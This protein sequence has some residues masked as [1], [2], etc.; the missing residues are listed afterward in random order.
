MVPLANPE[1]ETALIELGSTLAKDRD[2][3]LVAVHVVTIPDQTPLPEAAARIEDF[4]PGSG[5]LLERARQD[6]DTFDVPIETHRILS[7]RSFEE[8]SD[9][10]R[11]HRADMVVM[12]WGRHGAPGRMEST[13]DGLTHDL[14]C[15]FLVLRDRSM[16]PDRV[17]VPTA[18]GPDSELSARVASV[19]QRG[20]DAEIT[21]LHVADN[22]NAGEKFLRE[23][24]TENGSKGANLRVESGDVEN[25]IETAAEDATMVMVTPI[26]RRPG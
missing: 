22:T 6:A 10:A 17:L 21:L 15:D 1:H 8:I 9:A 14:P 18:G 3:E 13:I 16:S 25:A 19:F 5:E 23:W 12:G 2:G 4:D 7:H 24:A 20:Y 26:S 11:T